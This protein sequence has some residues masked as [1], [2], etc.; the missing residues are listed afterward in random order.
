MQDPPPFL[1]I[2]SSPYLT[3]HTSTQNAPTHPRVG[4]PRTTSQDSTH[5]RQ[6]LVTVSSL[7]STAQCVLSMVGSI[8]VILLFAGIPQLIY[9][10][11]VQLSNLLTFM[12]GASLI[13]S[14]VGGNAFV[15][16]K[17]RQYLHARNMVSAINGFLYTS[18]RNYYK[19]FIMHRRY[20]CICFKS[21][22]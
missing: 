7:Y 6:R 16:Y 13:T 10:P 18:W 2:R 15:N 17:Y 22:G 14:M 12:L 20:V 19:V 8:G 5:Y 4:T 21:I 9:S 3:P 11:S 1:N